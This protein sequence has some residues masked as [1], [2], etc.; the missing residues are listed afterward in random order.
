MIPV[1]DPWPVRLL[2]LFLL[3]RR[4]PPHRL[5]QALHSPNRRRLITLN[6]SRDRDRA[7]TS[8]RSPTSAWPRRRLRL[9][10]P[11]LLTISSTAARQRHRRQSPQHRQPRAQ[12][13]HCLYRYLSLTLLLP[14]R[15]SPPQDMPRRGYGNGRFKLNPGGSRTSSGFGNNLILQRIIIIL[16]I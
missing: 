6:R 14:H 7:T 3:D 2:L 13:L 15:T 12:Q 16:I 5:L 1:P 9:R 8:P 4:R 11:R 10:L